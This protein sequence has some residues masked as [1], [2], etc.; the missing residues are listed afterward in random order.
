[1]IPNS[2]P[3]EKKKIMNHNIRQDEI[4]SQHEGVVLLLRT[5]C[6]IFCRLY[7]PIVGEGVEARELPKLP[8]LVNPG[9][10]EPLVRSDIMDPPFNAVIKFA[11]SCLED[12]VLIS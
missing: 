9:A 10:V 5:F 6:S 7:L 1:M 4:K 12:I 2:K 11:N 3:Y 8:L